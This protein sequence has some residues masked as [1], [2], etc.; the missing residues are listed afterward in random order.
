MGRAGIIPPAGE[1]RPRHALAALQWASAR[2]Y[3]EWSAILAEETGIDVGYRRSGGVEVACSGNE[4]QDLRS[5]AGHWRI[6]GVAYERLAP[7]DFERVEPAL[8]PELAAAY[9]LPDQAQIRNP[10]LLQALKSAVSLRGGRIMPW[11]RVE[12]VVVEHGR[13]AA[14]RT[15]VGDLACG[16][17]IVAAGAWTGPLLKPLGINAATTPV[18]GQMLLLRTDRPL[19]RRIIEYGKSY[20]VPRD[21]GHTLVG[22]TEEDAGFDVTTSSR[23]ARDLMATA[24]KLCPVLSQANVLATWAG[25]RPGNHDGHPYIGRAAGMENIIVASGHK[26][27]GLQLAPATAEVVVELVLGRSPSIDLTPFSLDR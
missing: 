5:S 14:V 2:L 17:V 4:E 20:V 23:V 27:A 6:D 24:L 10:H 26:R 1:N 3:P 18:K 25:L 7:G 15:S 16:V 22:S 13:V 9:F 21:D 19:V 8:N 11:N 12:E